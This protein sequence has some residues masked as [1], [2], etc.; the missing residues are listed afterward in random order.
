MVL[1]LAEFHFK[2]YYLYKRQES[3][4][5]YIHSFYSIRQ[6]QILLPTKIQAISYNPFITFNLW[7]VSYC[8]NVTNDKTL[9]F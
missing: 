1:V 7:V 9:Q 5:R 8:K 3:G 6:L 2:Q 4:E